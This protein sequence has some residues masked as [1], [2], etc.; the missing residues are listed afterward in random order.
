MNGRPEGEPAKMRLFCIHYAGATASIF[1]S[2]HDALP[3]EVELVA[4]QMPGREYRF[5]EPL[6][7]D[8]NEIA[9]A[10]A[11]AIAPLLDKPYALFGHSMGILIGFNVVRE[12]RARGLRQPGFLVASGRNA[13]QFKWAD[14]GMEKLPDEEFVAAVRDYNGTPEALL[15]DPS[16]WD[17]WLPRLRA[18]LAVSAEYEHEDQ[19]P[20][21][22][23]ILVLFAD[24]DRLA[25]KAGLEGWRAQTTSDVRYVSFTGDHFFLH[26]SEKDVLAEVNVELRRQLEETG[27]QSDTRQHNTRAAVGLA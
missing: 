19:P 5:S 4:V 8:M 24:G 25:T 18:D 14:T 27:G 13:P 1:K 26:G 6:L 11:D 22:C 2:W 20:L 15:S 16:M 3:P 12:L 7:T 21:D 10:I 17:L 23:P 9:P